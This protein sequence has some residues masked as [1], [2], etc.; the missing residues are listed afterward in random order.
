MKTALTLILLNLY[1]GAFSQNTVVRFK[2]DS[3]YSR[4]KLTDEEWGIWQRNKKMDKHMSM[5]L[6][7]D[8]TNYILT[9]TTQYEKESPRTH[10]YKI[11]DS[12]YDTTK[13]NIGFTFLDI[14]M[15]SENGNYLNWFL[16]N[17]DGKQS[18]ITTGDIMQEKYF[19]QE[20]D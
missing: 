11:Y 10:S 15:K 1:I 8:A 17:N 2:V 19:L 6:S 16:I 5:F 3:T 4:L 9:L 7:I 20:I 18:I 12:Q 13:K 14:K